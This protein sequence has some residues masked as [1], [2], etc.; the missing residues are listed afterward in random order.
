[1]MRVGNNLAGTHLDERKPEVL[2]EAND[3]GTILPASH[4]SMIASIR[5]RFHHR[6]EETGATSRG[7]D[8]CAER[9]R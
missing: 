6:L 3:A 4:S 5:R 1:M 7:R 9:S 8:E 2:R